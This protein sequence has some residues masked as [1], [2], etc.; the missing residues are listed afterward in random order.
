MHRGRPPRAMAR[1]AFTPRGCPVPSRVPTL[2]GTG[3]APKVCV[4][5]TSRKTCRRGGGAPVDEP[6]LNAEEVERALRACAWVR[7]TADFYPLLRP[8]LRARLTE[9]PALAAK[10]SRLDNSQA[11]R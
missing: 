3:L 4:R 2:A 9:D 10:V 8:F 6:V 7:V 11:Y 1:H 5:R